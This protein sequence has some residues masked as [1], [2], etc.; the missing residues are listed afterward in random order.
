MKY[1]YVDKEW[2]DEFAKRLVEQLELKGM[3]QRELAEALEISPNMITSYKKG[4]HI[5][6]AVRI[7]EMAKII[8]CCTDDLIGF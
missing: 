4:R 7:S 3:E 1:K 6:S 8:G 5:P 2:S